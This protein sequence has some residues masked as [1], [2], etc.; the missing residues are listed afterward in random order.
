MSTR[1]VRVVTF[2]GL[3]VVLALSLASFDGQASGSGLAGYLVQAPIFSESEYQADNPTNGFRAYFGEGGMRI[4]PSG[5]AESVSWQWSLALSAHGRE[6][7]LEYVSPPAIQAAGDRFTF[8]YGAVEETILNS[9]SGLEQSLVVQAPISSAGGP[10]VVDFV[11]GG[12]LR[13][14]LADGQA[15]QFYANEGT[16]LLRFAKLQ[17]TD[18]AGLELPV[19]MQWADV[20]GS[21]NDRGIRLV[22]EDASASYPVTVRTL[23]SAANVVAAPAPHS[24]FVAPPNDTCAGAEVVADG[25]YPILSAITADITD[26]TT[27]G[28]PAPSC[29]TSWSR[30]I[31]YSFTPSVSANYT[32]SLCADAPTGST[33]DDTVVAVFTSAA[34]CAG[35]FTQV[36]GGCDDDSCA[37]EGLQSVITDLPLTGGTT[38]YVLASKFGATAPTVGNTAIQLKVSRFIPPPP[39]TNDTCAGAEVIPGAGFPVLSAVTDLFSATSAGDPATTCEPI[40]SRGIW[41]T[42]TPAVNGTYQFETCNTATGTTLSDTVLSLFTSAGGCA[43]PFTQVGCN[44]DSCGLQSS[45]PLTLT[46]GTTYYLL[47]YK[48]GAT[49]PPS[50]ASNVQVRVTQVFPPVNDTCTGALPLTLNIPVTDAFTNLTTNDYQLSGATC[51]TGVGQ[52]SNTAGGRDHAFT[53]TAPAAG[54]YSFRVSEPSGGFGNPILY[55]A[56]SCPAVPPSPQTVTGCL[57]AANR[58]SLST[59]GGEEVLCFPMTASQQVFVIV[60]DTSLTTLPTFTLEVAPCT[61]ET[62][63]NG[64]AATA[65]PFVCGI[66]GA[67]NPAS[68]FDFFSFPPTTAGQRIFAMAD[69][70]VSNTSDF[71]MRITTAADTLEYDDANLDA[72][73]GT[74]APVCAGTKA[75]GAA[76]YIRMSHF[77]GTLSEPYRVYAT[78]QSPIECAKPEIE[79]N[80]TRATANAV[81]SGYVSGTLSS[82]SD[83][84]YFAV[85]VQAGDVIFVAVDQDPGY[86]NT[87]I[88]GALSIRSATDT[89]LTSA[90]DGGST[91]STRAPVLASLTSTTPVSNGEGLWYRAPA[92]GTYYVRYEWFGGTTPND[93]LM[94]IAVNCASAACVDGVPCTLD[95]CVAGT[96]CTNTPDN[97]L[98]NDNNLCTSDVCDPVLGCVFTPSVVCNDNSLCTTDACDPATGQCVFT[99]SVVCNDGLLCTTDACDPATGQCV[100]TPVVCN[101][102][103]LCTTDACDPATGLCVFTPIV[104][105]DQ[106]VCTADSCDP[107][108][109]CVFDPAPLNGTTCDDGNFCTAPDV[110]RNG[111]CVC[112]TPPGGFTTQIDAY[113]DLGAGFANDTRFDYSSAVNGIGSPTCSHR[114]DIGF[115]C[116]FYNDT[117]A[118]GSGPRFVCNVGFTPGRG[119]SYPKDPGHLPASITATGWYTF[120]HIFKDVGGVLVID[121]EILPVGSATPVASW[122]IYA[123]SHPSAA[124]G[125]IITSPEGP[126]ASPLNPLDFVSG[127]F[128]NV[129]GGRYGWLV[130]NEMPFLAIDNTI[131]TATGFNQGFEVDNSGW[132]VLAGQYTA[133]RVPSGNNGVS[134]AAGVF[135]GEAGL[136]TAAQGGSAFTDWG[137]DRN[138]RCAFPQGVCPGPDCNDQNPCTTDTCDPVLGCVHTPIVCNDNNLCTTDACDPATGLCVYTPIVC[139]DNSPCTTDACDPATGQCVYTPVPDG[140]ACGSAADTFCDDPDTCVGGVCRP[141]LVPAGTA[142]GDN[143][144]CTTADACDGA[145]ACVGGPAVDCNDNNVCT[146]EVCDPTTLT[147]TPGFRNYDAALIG[148]RYRSFGNVVGAGEAYLGIPDLGVAGNRVERNFHPC[149]WGNTSGN[150]QTNAITFT[151]DKAADL[152]ITTVDT[153]APGCAFSLTYP[154]LTANLAVKKPGFLLSQ[155]NIMQ[156]TVSGRDTNTT[157]SL[158]S[159]TFN[160]TPLGTFTATQPPGQFLDWMVTGLE[161]NQ[162]F[163]MTATLK[164]TGAFGGSQ[165][166]SRVGLS[167]GV[168]RTLRPSGCVYTNNTSPC[169]DSNRCTEN[170]VCAAGTCTGSAVTCN[171]QN[172]CTD[173]TCDPATGCVYTNDDTNVCTDNSVCTTGDACVAGQ[174]VGTPIP[175]D[176]GNPCTDDTCD[177]ILGCVYTPDDTNTCS[178]GNACTAPDVCVGGACVCRNFGACTNSGTVTTFTNTTPVVIPTGPG[179]VTSTITV[180]G[181]NPY[182]FRLRMTNFILHA[183]NSDLDVTLQSPAGTVVTI[184]TDNGGT[185]DN[186]FN[187]TVWDDKADPGNDVPFPSDTFAASKLVTDT[188]YS[189]NVAKATLAVE[190]A[191]GAFTGENPN[192]VWTLT[193]SDDLSSNG[194]TLQSWGLETTTL[195]IAPIV[196][197]NPAVVQTTAVPLPDSALAS[198]TVT[199]S[200]LGTQIGAV[201]LKTFIRHTFPS[202]LDI[203]LVSPAGTVVTITSDNGSSFDNV[204]NGTVWSDKADPGGQVPYTTNNGVVTD[205]SY[206]ANVTRTPLVSE[207]P[208]SAFVGE[209]PNGVWTLKIRDD[210]GGDTGSLDRWELEVDTIVCSI[211]CDVVCDD[212]NPCTD[213]TCDPI[214]GCVYTIDDTNTC[215]DN[216]VCT[217]GD[218]CQAGQCVGTPITCD[219][220]NPC[221]D[222]TCDPVTGCVFTNDDTNLCDD[223]NTCTINDACQRGVCTCA[224]TLCAG[225]LSYVDNQTPVTIPAGP[226]VVTSTITVTGLDPYIQTVRLK[227]FILHAANADLD[228]TLQSPAGTVVTITTDNGGTFDNVFNGTVWD[229]KAD[230]GNQAPFPGNTFAASN[231]VG[232]TVFVDNVP[233][234]SLVTEEALGAFIGENPN[235][236]WTLTI[237]DD[238]ASNGGELTSWG[239]ELTTLPAAPATAVSTVSE[240]VV[241]PIP[242]LGTV[243]RTVAVSGAGIQIGKVKVTTFITHSFPGDLDM[244]LKSPSGTIVTLTSDNGSLSN[245]VFNGTVWDDDANPGGQVP[246]VNNNGLVTDHL[247][248][249]NVLASPLAPEEALAAFLGENPNGTWTLTVTDDASLDTGTLSRWQLEITTISCASACDLDC[250]DNDACTADTCD[251]LTG[252]IHTPITCNDNSL[253]TTDTCNPAIGCVYTPIVCND[254]SFCTTDTCDPLTGCVYTTIVCDDNNQCTDDSC[255]P[256]TGCVYTNDNTNTCTDGNACTTDRCFNGFC[257]TQGID[258]NDNNLCTNDSCSA[259][260]GCVNTPVTCNDNNNCTTDS[261]DPASGCR[262]T[263]VSCDDQNACTN[264]SCDPLTERCVNTP[265]NCGDNNACTTDACDPASGCTHTTV[266][267][268]DANKCT[269]DS[270]VPATGCVFTPVVCNDG[271]PCTTDACDPASGCT[272]TTNSCNDNNACTNDSCNPATGACVNTPIVCNDSNACTADA[273]NPASGCTFTPITC[274]DSN[275]CT[276]DACN[277]TTGCTF[278]PIVCNDNSACT[279]DACNPASGCTFTTIT[280]NDSNPCTD[281]S[282]SPSSGCVYTNDNTNTCTDGNACTAD[283]CVAGQCVSTP[284]TCNDGNACTDDS[285]N[286]TSGCVYTNDDTNAC[287]DGNACTADRCVAGQCVGTPTTCND[288]NPCTDDTCDPGSGCIYTRDDTNPCTDNNACTSDA[289]V[290]GQCTSTPITCN[291]NNPCTDDSCNVTS[292]CVYTPDNTNVCADNNACTTD[293]CVAGQCV[294]TPITCNDSNPCTDDS[295]NPTSGCVYTNDNTN[296]C[297]DGN[298]CTADACVNGQCV[299]APIPC[300]DNNPCTDDSCNPSSGC[301]FAPDNTNTCTDGNACT[302]DTCQ[303]GQCVST[304]ISCNDGNSCTIDTCNPTTGC[305]YQCKPY[306]CQDGDQCAPLGPGGSSFQVGNVTVTVD[307]NGDVTVVYD[308]SR[309]LN[310]NSYGTNIVNWPRSHNFSDLVGSDKAQFVFRDANGNVVF[311]FLM[312]Y[313]T[314]SSGTPSGYASLGVAGGEGSVTTG[315][316]SWLLQWNT[317]LA[318]NLNSTGYCSGGSCVVG[319]V[320]LLQNSPPTTPPNTSYTVAPAYSLWNFT[321]SYTVKISHLAFGAAGFGSV[322]IPSVHNSPPKVGSNAVVP[323]PCDECGGGGN[324]SGPDPDADGFADACDNCPTIANADQADA[325][326]DGL[327]DACDACPNDAQN[328]VDHDGVCGNVDNCPTTANPSQAD[329]DGNGVGDACDCNSVPCNDGNPCTTDTCNPAT[330][331]CTH[332]P[333]TGQACNDG[334]TCTTGDACDASG[335]CVGAPVNCRDESACTYDY[336]DPVAGCL[337]VGEGEDQTTSISSYFNST[338]IPAGKWLWFNANLKMSMYYDCVPTIIYSTNNVI[339]FSANG[340][341]Y[342]LNAPDAVI[343]LDPNATCSTTTWNGALNRWEIVAPVT[344]T[345]EIFFTGLGFQVPVNFPGGIKPVS[346]TTTLSSNQPGVEF[347]W[348]WGAAVY[349][350]DMSNYAGLGVKPTTKKSCAYN[351]TDKAGT[352]E[353]K[354]SFVMKGARG[355]GGTNYTGSWTSYKNVSLECAD[356]V[357]PEE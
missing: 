205:A 174:C 10:L 204:F 63:P 81:P 185:F 133:I 114:R 61:L 110:C 8:S 180:G 303:G 102:N 19:T 202:D 36:S 162:S 21:A 108:V 118:T 3:A 199:V 211:P 117:D 179:V 261:C 144:P 100:F 71:D 357:H 46:G 27:T 30:G 308:Q 244:T 7:G 112:A 354:K 148:L 96:G 143:N 266:E 356:I 213:D 276:A 350:T 33:V 218:A 260:S 269:N 20:K 121:M 89:V 64:T 301:V 166:L 305:S 240:A 313:I 351:N 300:N 212:G 252:C 336:C 45:V 195:A 224:G 22:V 325:D 39:P 249:D 154:N 170:D 225:T 232:D 86:N 222:D 280:C 312:D 214:L 217:T 28:D 123:S 84:D 74:L 173:D 283:A 82:T 91:S 342:T 163:T 79:S 57:A 141:N 38:Y 23:I 316:A 334:N 50:S 327:G 147:V 333:R 332:A 70:F 297:T 306:P 29:Q 78:V 168:D 1:G 348:R 55:L 282:C 157:V 298:A 161:F 238:L 324:C 4:V 345:D 253:C 289:C 319:G 32:F 34:G 235:G 171:D 58:N 105:D 119:N 242:D 210:L 150:S 151:F 290:A 267:C 328:D 265:I 321:N 103:S 274:N 302:R 259:T 109:G 187:G 330:G 339:T 196:T 172:P 167:V 18:N 279:A 37:S 291:D 99:P 223:G 49:A 320:N 352:P 155:M 5:P 257:Q 92:A 51:F 207:E 124:G 237:S 25:P 41:Y 158:E 83:I 66:E 149:A 191:L 134:S 43:G 76:T 256:A 277:P 322:S 258:C 183:A 6:A 152:L 156:I 122:T 169:D 44:D 254:G 227:D 310:D 296:L 314:A 233:K 335:F 40:T 197:T 215:S 65:T 343:T 77:S 48:F 136:F 67:I 347:K 226:A 16:T 101:D 9:Q 221:T 94:S 12:T 275:A 129:G 201:R 186:V 59:P 329:S 87:A 2:L 146:D 270:C 309:G 236:L 263:T 307:G 175:C 200:G 190:E 287:S 293:A 338:P 315:Q 228:V 164:L 125:G 93:Y 285:C 181:V 56:S 131:N 15:V 209:D 318:S 262:Y 188:T 73:F 62:E 13:G 184:T 142:C 326:D 230:P 140:T 273:C 106:N 353:T 251:P 346:W 120:R 60:D 206:V 132:N 127:P 115:T 284:I 130:D 294:S 317:S 107:L 355:G 176:D 95:A 231:L 341:P 69:G 98:C 295:C 241:T 248:V 53:F 247:Y 189:D 208:L 35:P 11:L 159:L 292:G 323:T 68:E 337:H 219:D 250:D 304:T 198:S 80:N 75:T 288:N 88:N 177:P 246:Y 160:G 165:E 85:T 331:A 192:G 264:D 52:T 340:V 245:D 24:G 72:L 203:T 268:Y 26:A 14:K 42:F 182:L 104:C 31:W 349:G 17:A 311:D 229:D 271:N 272:H 234:T 286:P 97:G 239:I 128:T 139:D 178:D 193:I 138:A 243:T 255:N 344:G 54:N 126:V 278:T 111:A 113:L 220:S 137:G 90:N 47:G 116:G 194:G 216:N 299:V 135:H 281:D 145:G 153:G